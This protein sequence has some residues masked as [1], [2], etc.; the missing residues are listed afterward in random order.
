MDPLKWMEDSYDDY[1]RTVEEFERDNWWTS[2]LTGVIFWVYDLG[3][4]YLL[5]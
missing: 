4:L 1:V 3:M 2:R 5:W